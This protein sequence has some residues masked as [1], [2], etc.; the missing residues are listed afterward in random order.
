MPLVLAP[1]AAIALG[2]LF[3]FGLGV[4][5]R[6]ADLHFGRRVVLL[7]AGLSFAP[8]VGYFAWS[9]PSWSVAYLYDGDRLPSAL[10]L[11]AVIASCALLF[12]AF[13]ATV[14]ALSDGLQRRA[15]VGGFAP[16]V[17]GLALLAAWG[18]RLWLVGSHA[19]VRGGFSVPTLSSTATGV[20]VV[21]MNV[22]LGIAASVALSAL[23]TPHVAPA[24]K[25]R[26]N[27]VVRGASRGG[28]PRG[29]EPTR[30]PSKHRPKDP[31]RSRR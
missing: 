30:K 14:A 21:G 28:E 29:L 20:A 13:E 15:L 22:L 23:R 17:V 5:E 19:E 11:A 16:V 3:G 2:V 1:F 25:R 26:P 9:V 18:D 31:T 12:G 10:S 24:P 7:F 27:L 8:V 6:A 4:P